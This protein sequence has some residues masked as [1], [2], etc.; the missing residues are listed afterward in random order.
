[1]VPGPVKF[2]YG[3]VGKCGVLKN[4]INRDIYQTLELG[5][6]YFHTDR[7]LQNEKLKILACYGFY[8]S[9]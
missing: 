1:M 7:Y 3:F 2:R 8:V 9:L 4:I 5:V 6:R